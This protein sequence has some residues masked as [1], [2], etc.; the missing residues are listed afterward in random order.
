[1]LFVFGCV[2]G[3][4]CRMHSSCHSGRHLCSGETSID[5]VGVLELVQD[6]LPS[7]AQ[8]AVVER[9]RL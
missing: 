2:M 3:K 9:A 5:D 4:S 1:M 7:I 8:V 6:A